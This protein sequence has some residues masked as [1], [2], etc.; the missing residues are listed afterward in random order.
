MPLTAPLVFL[1]AAI[2]LVFSLKDAPLFKGFVGEW[3][4]SRLLRRKLDQGTYQLIDNL[5][6]ARDTDT[7]QIDPVVVSVHGLFVIET[8]NYRG[9]I[10]GRERDRNWTQQIYSF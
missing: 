2:I 9:W 10:F 3:R 5:L 6:L 8:K 7:T 1:A 4:V